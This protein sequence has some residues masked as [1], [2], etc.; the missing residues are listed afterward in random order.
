M[1]R[2]GSMISKDLVRDKEETLMVCRMFQTWQILL[3]VSDS[4]RLDNA[5]RPSRKSPSRGSWPHWKLLQALACRAMGGCQR[6]TGCV[7]R[8]GG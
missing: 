5:C 7:R 2:A 8:D 3:A 6:K 1:P 4:P